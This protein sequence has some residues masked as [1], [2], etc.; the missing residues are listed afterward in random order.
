M[1][2]DPRTMRRPEVYQRD[3]FPPIAVKEPIA[4]VAHVGQKTRQPRS[5]RRMGHVPFP[6]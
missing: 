6:L 2:S 4:V 5:V 1:M 3:I